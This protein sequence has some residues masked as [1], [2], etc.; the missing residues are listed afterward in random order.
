[1]STN[2]DT[3]ADRLANILLPVLSTVVQSLTMPRQDSS[4]SWSV[5]VYLILGYK[6]LPH[7]YQLIQQ[8]LPPGV[9][10]QV[11]DEAIPLGYDEGRPKKVHLLTPITRTL[12]RQHRFVLKVSCTLYVNMQY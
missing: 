7:R 4:S 9:G 6:L 1:M 2:G 3:T 11:W 8:S 10:L 12:A 5:D